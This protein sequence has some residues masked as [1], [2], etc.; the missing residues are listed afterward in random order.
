M[1]FTPTLSMA[2]ADYRVFLDRAL[3]AG[4]LQKSEFTAHY[5]RNCS[6]ARTD[7]NIMYIPRFEMD[8]EVRRRKRAVFA[9]LVYINYF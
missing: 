5:L 4:S 1:F 2:H 6:G 7:Q 3:T 9:Y 8:V